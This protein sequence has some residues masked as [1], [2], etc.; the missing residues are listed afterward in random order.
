MQQFKSDADRAI[1]LAEKAV[2]LA[3]KATP[4]P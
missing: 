1:G 4:V 3:Q 2:G